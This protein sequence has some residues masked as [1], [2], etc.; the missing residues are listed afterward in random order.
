M[1]WDSSV[2][3]HVVIGEMWTP[4]K[5]EANETALEDGSRIWSVYH[6]KDGTKI[7]VI[8]EAES[9]EGDPNFSPKHLPAAARGI[10][11]KSLR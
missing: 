11:M 5:R 2:A 3:M 10:L 4:T 6:L 8:T 1:R 9:V 7:W